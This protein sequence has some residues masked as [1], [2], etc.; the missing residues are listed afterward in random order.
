[1][2]PEYV[3]DLLLCLEVVNIFVDR[4]YVPSLSSPR[5][6]EVLESSVARSMVAKMT[7]GLW[8][9]Y[10]HIYTFL[11]RDSKL[12]LGWS[13]LYFEKT[14][15]MLAGLLSTNHDHVRATVK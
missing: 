8:Y 5:E 13:V 1:M 2:Y 7:C 9:I 10:I 12:S 4:Y 11:L 6:A 15:A 3:R 14:A